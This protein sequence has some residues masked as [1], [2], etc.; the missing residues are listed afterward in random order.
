[1][2]QVAES[3][4]DES[5]IPPTKLDEEFS[6]DNDRQGVEL[7]P[8]EDPGDSVSSEFTHF[9]ETEGPGVVRA[10]LEQDDDSEWVPPRRSTDTPHMTPD[11][12]VVGDT[13]GHEA[14]EEVY[15]QQPFQAE[16]PIP[17]HTG[18]VPTRGETQRPLAYIW[19]FP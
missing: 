4:D 1:M 17:H 19:S 3:D 18:N 10:S 13:N 16:E 12:C 5:F 7:S 14:S 9:L 15:T 11:T 8:L 2:R 6:P